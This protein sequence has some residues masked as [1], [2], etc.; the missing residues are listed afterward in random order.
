MKGLGGKKKAKMRRYWKIA[1]DNE[2]FGLFKDVGHPMILWSYCNT[3]FYFIL[4][5]YSNVFSFFL[6]EIVFTLSTLCTDV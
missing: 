6:I 4:Q 5:I 1:I 3:N 2:P